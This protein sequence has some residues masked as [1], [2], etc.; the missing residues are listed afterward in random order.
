MRP[1][2]ILCLLLFMK[3][4]AAQE[5]YVYTEPASNM[6]AKSLGVRLTG[7]IMKDKHADQAS[8]M[9]M[10]ELMW[11][12]SRKIMLHASAFVS[13]AKGQAD[14]NGGLLYA[15]YRLYSNDD[16]HDHTRLAAYGKYAFTNVPVHDRYINLNN[17]N[18]GYE[19]GL[20]MTRL[21]KKTAVSAAASFLHANTNY[22]QHAHLRSR[23]R[24]ALGYTAS[25]GRLFL[26]KVYKSYK[27]TNLNLM[28]ELLGQTNL[29]NGHSLLDIAP[30]AQ[31]I[32]NSRLRA[33]IG[34]RIPAVRS[35]YR[36]MQ[37]GL[38][39]RFEY[40]FFNVY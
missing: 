1:M 7:N 6:A 40:N 13:D 2:L 19:G 28:L 38:L 8:Y 39:L 27:Q 25:I 30:S 12:V 10:P 16:V 34:Y 32:F 11:G 5:L 15:K 26:P 21:R 17:G 31:L 29:Y 35:L 3:G 9:L 22:G 20:V 4:T 33:D 23:E 18:T 24:N 36:N 37:P 14:L